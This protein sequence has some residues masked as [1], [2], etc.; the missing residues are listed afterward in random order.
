MQGVK[1]VE[2]RKKWR[3]CGV[4]VRA[5]AKMPGICHEAQIFW[6][7][8]V[9]MIKDRATPISAKPGW[10]SDISLLPHD[11]WRIRDNI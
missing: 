11:E 9:C 2:A 1:E 10:Q 7:E 4:S 3:A 8:E 5:S 6:H